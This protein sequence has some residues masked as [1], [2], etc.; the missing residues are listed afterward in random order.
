MNIQLAYAAGSGSLQTAKHLM[1]YLQQHDSSDAMFTALI[2][3]I[4]RTRPDQMTKDSVLEIIKLFWSQFHCYLQDQQSKISLH[5]F[6]KPSPLLVELAACNCGPFIPWTSAAYSTAVCKGSSKP[7]WW[8]LHE[9]K[10]ADSKKVPLGCSPGRTLLLV[11]GH[12]WTVPTRPWWYSDQSLAN[13]ERLFFTFY[14][15]AHRH[16][17]LHR[18]YANHLAWLGSLPHVLLKKIA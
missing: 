1:P 12:G 16:S 11:H 3:A 7:L 8:L 13:A 15:A 5:L 4:Y 14:C 2:T 10:S 6:N 17:L 18:P 9:C